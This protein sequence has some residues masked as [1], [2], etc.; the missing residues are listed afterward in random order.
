MSE[1]LVARFIEAL[2]RLE[3]DREVGTI[4]ELFGD[5]AR[6]AN[7][8]M[9]DPVIGS[10]GA[11]SFWSM[12]RDT[13]GTIASHFDNVFVCGDKAALEWTARGTGH[14]GQPIRYR[15]VSIL[16]M[17]GDRLSRFTAYFDPADLGAQLG[18]HIAAD[19]ARR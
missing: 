14:R 15:G 6:I 4:A 1:Q 7:V 17:Q 16:E 3:R 18:R 2:G 10:A 11:R 12:Y 9:P 19:E 8:I 13:F 5:D